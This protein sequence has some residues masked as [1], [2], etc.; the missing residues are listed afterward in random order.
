MD[1]ATQMKAAV[2]FQTGQPLVIE[3]RIEIP[4][5]QPGQVLVKVAYSGLCRSQLLEVRGGRG[6]DPYLPHLLGHEGTGEVIAVGE[7]VSKVKAGDSVILGWIKGSGADVGGTVYRKGEQ[8]FNAGGVTTLSDYSVVSENRCV[9]LPE[10]VPLDVGVL[11]GCA[12]PTGAGIV[13]N[14]IDPSPGSSIAVVGMGGIGLSALMATGLYQC[15]QVIA[16]DIEPE[17][18]QLARDFGADQVINS[19]TEN[20]VE[21]ILELTGGRGVDFSLEAAGTAESIEQA[22][23]VVRDRGGLCVFASHPD[24]RERIRLDPHDL[25]RGKQIRGSWGGGCDPDRDIPRFAQL[26]RQGRLP[27]D[28]LLSHRYKLNRINRALDD[29]EQRKIVR[30]LIEIN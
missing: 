24:S 10:G 26:Y 27:L 21:R 13:I 17:K 7:R 20:V 8:S 25:I 28:Q 3:D 22:F 4:R 15:S 30:A 1:T 18:L 14:E 29:L 9:A 5:L 16:V 12:V 19:A 11:F 2:L 6:D 23:K